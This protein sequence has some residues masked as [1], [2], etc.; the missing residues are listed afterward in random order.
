MGKMH[1]KAM[2]VG[3]LVSCGTS[4]VSAESADT[5]RV[6]FSAGP[7][8]PESTR[9]AELSPG[10]EAMHLQRRCGDIDCDGY[11]FTVPDI[12][13]WIDYYGSL[14]TECENVGCDTTWLECAT[15]Q[16]DMNGDGYPWT[17]SDLM[18]FI[19][20]FYYAW[21]PCDTIEPFFSDRDI[22]RVLDLSGSPSEI[23]SVFISLRN[24]SPVYGCAFRIV[25]DSTLL[26]PMSS[27]SGGGWVVGHAPIGIDNPLPP[28][29]SI[30][31]EL[32]FVVDSNATIGSTTYLAFE[33]DT[34]MPQFYSSL[35]DS[36]GTHVVPQFASGT[37]SIVP[38]PCGDCNGDGRIAI[39]D[40]TYLVGFVYR[41]G[42][43]PVGEGDVNLDGRVT[44]AD[45]TYIAGHV[46]R[47]GSEPCNP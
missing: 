30:V 33:D 1:K 22:M 44:I 5:L 2:F 17:V 26:T 15:A 37:L 46:Y 4:T 19:G 21:E 34:L 38:Y 11:Y 43:T 16:S 12:M 8:R 40:A 20:Y 10:S 29:S 41:G 7:E 28:G 14:Y 13:A 36:V 32:Q 18:R 3:L 9:V 27:N 45:A 47:G 42:P 24:T 23:V 25:C 6:P 35:S 39:A 31:A